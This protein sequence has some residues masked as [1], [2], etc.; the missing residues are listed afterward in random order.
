MKKK[1]RRVQNE[2]SAAVKALV[3][4]RSGG[5]CEAGTPVCTKRAVL[6]HHRKRRSQ[7]GKGTAENALHACT[8]CHLYLHANLPEAY[9]NGWIIRGHDVERAEPDAG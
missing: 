7:G 2:F 6:F 8:P 1:V 5:R 9:A 4:K 3:I